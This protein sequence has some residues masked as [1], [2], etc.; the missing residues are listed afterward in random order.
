M[1]ITTLLLGC[2]LLLANA[3]VKAQSLLDSYILQGI[4][5]ND[6]L[7]QK[8]LQ[9]EKSTW[10]L[11]E[12]RS[13][14]LP[15]VS[16][17]GSY[18]LSQGGRSI[19]LP[20]GDLLNPVYQTLNQLTQSQ[21]FPQIEN[22]NEQLNPNNFYDIK[23]RTSMPLVNADIWYNRKIKEGMIPLQQAQVDMYKRDLVRDIKTAYFRYQQATE[24]A[25]IYREA[26]ALVQ[27]NIRVNQSLVA[28]GMAN[29]TVV[30]RA[31][32]ELS[33]L[34]AQI[35]EAENNRRNAAAYVNFLLNRPLDAAIL[36]D[37]SLD[38]LPPRVLDPGTPEQRE[39]L[40]QIRTSQDLQGLS[41]QLNKAY[42]LPKVNTFVDL[43]SQGFNFAFDGPSMY[44]LAGLSL[45][46]NLFSGMRN[47]YKIQQ[48]QLD[49]DV[50][51]KQLDYVQDQLSLQIVTLNNSLN[52]AHAIY[53]SN[54]TE[55]AANRRY[56]SDMQKRYRESQVSYIELL[57]AQTTL[58]QSLL[59]Q[60]ISRFTIWIQHA[61]LERANAGYLFR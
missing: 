34:E 48:T 11:K 61:E 43:G 54:E 27:E 32:S 49:L 15:S 14:Y 46:W 33:K 42:I 5:S 19:N 52:S 9:V 22:A 31:R 55:V 30:V 60:S 41:L 17:L 44:Y 57:D 2:V 37:S 36:P 39:E 1:R 56:L 59:Q 21:Q 6:M 24:A 25:G 12:A 8:E 3:P 28:N 23:F 7:R 18:T 51:Q 16:L 29:P 38:Q 50:T 13:L 53:Q 26:L 35:S 45:E 58:T 4:E 10:A 40:A 47:K 20:V